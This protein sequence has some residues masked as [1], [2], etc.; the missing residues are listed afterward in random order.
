MQKRGT[1]VGDVAPAP[2]AFEIAERGETPLAAT[3]I[4][5]REIGFTIVSLAFSLIAVVIPLLFM[6]DV[7]G[8]L[9]RE[10][11]VT[12]RFRRRRPSLTG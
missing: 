12:W 9:L 1:D 2:R 4:G 3:L 10:F 6:S 11:T 5:A 7:V 8:R